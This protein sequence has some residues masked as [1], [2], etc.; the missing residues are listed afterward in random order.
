M[1][2]SLPA[3]DIA[4]LLGGVVT[5][6]AVAFVLRTLPEV[7]PTT[8]A[9]ALLLLVLGIATFG[10]LWIATVT[11]VAA[12]LAFNFFFL[13]PLGTLTIADAQNWIALVAFLAVAGLAG[14]L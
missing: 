7:R 11:A 2:R 10:R 14:H 9:L 8:V 1:D 12:T 13:P 3:R 5:I 4:L 6:A